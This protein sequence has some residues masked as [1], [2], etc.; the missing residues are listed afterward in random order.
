MKDKTKI[1]RGNLY[2]WYIRFKTWY[3]QTIYFARDILYSIN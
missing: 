3:N 1:K 2:W